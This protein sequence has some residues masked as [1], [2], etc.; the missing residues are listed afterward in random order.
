MVGE[1]IWYNIYTVL[2]GQSDYIEYV[3]HPNLVTDIQHH[4]LH[5]AK[6]VKLFSFTNPL[7][8]YHPSFQKKL[9]EETKPIKHHY[10]GVS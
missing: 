9:L 8:T 6:E 7:S 1:I 3:L 4:N 5:L 10:M 2:T